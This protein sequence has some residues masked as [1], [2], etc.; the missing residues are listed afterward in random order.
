[1]APSG[2]PVVLIEQ[3]LELL[4][5][6]DSVVGGVPVEPLAD[7]TVSPEVLPVAVVDPV[8]LAEP[9]AE[10]LP[11]AATDPE[12]GATPLVASL[13]LAGVVPLVA[14]E[15]VVETEPDAAAPLAPLDPALPLA[16]PLLATPPSSVPSE[17]ST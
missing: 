17:N 1:M 2:C 10:G 4:L 8:V 14:G 7:P 16:A 3:P 12:P 6:V 5:A 11:L 13:P 9:L 15:P